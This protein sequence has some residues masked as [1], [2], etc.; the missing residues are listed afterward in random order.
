MEDHGE[1]GN[2]P[3]VTMQAGRQRATLP[4]IRKFNEHSERLLKSSLGDGPASKRRRTDANN[5]TDRMSQLDLDDLHDPLASDGIALQMQDRQRY[6]EGQ[7]RGTS[8]DAQANVDPSLARSSA[9]HAIRSALAELPQFKPERKPTETALVAM[10]QGVDGQVRAHRRQDDIPDGLLRQMT[11]CQTAATEFLRQFWLA[12]YPPPNAPPSSAAQRTQRTAK[13]ASYLV[14]T[15]EKVD[16]LIRAAQGI[17]YSRVEEAMKP[18]LKAVD[19]ALAF[20][21]ARQTSA[22]NGKR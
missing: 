11:T 21:H 15:P 19:N 5:T 18:I 3:D 22:V 20:H 8:S 13:M 2:L 16:A 1:T 10:T 17:D 14:R 12:V 4:L 6:F 7:A 9:V